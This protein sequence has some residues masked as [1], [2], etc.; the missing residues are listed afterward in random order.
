MIVTWLPAW[1][2]GMPEVK[3]RYLLDAPL[4]SLLRSRVSLMLYKVSVE[5]WHGAIIQ[6]RSRESQVRNI[7]FGGLGVETG[8]IG[9]GLAKKEILDF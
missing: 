9:C 3:S 5:R 6:G 8:V 7:F 2:V 1:P 4:V